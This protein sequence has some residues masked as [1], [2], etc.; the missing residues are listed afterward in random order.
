MKSCVF[1]LFR[2]KL[3]ND[4]ISQST[5][6]LISNISLFISVNAW[7]RY[8]LQST[9][10]PE[11]EMSDEADPE[12]LIHWFLGFRLWFSANQECLIPFI[13]SLWFKILLN[14]FYTLLKG[15]FGLSQEG[16]SWSRPSCTNSLLTWLWNKVFF[17]DFA[18]QFLFQKR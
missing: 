9:L 15:F 8:R 14:S 1:A 17:W 5:Q 4:R 18:H 11:D 6:L 10:L 16:N 3:N 7:W 2:H 13:K 12:K